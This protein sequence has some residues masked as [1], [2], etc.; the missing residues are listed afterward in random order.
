MMKPDRQLVCVLG[1]PGTGKGTQGK[2]LASYL[3]GVHVSVGDLIRESEAAGRRVPKDR[4]TK[5]AD[6][7]AT[8]ELIMAAAGDVAGTVVLDGFPRHAS[9]VEALLAMPWPCRT[10]ID[11]RVTFPV[12][13]ARMKGRGR[14]GEDPGRIAQRHTM[15]D[16]NRPGLEVALAAARIALVPV[17]GEGT[18]DE[19]QNLCR[20][21]IH[22]HCG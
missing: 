10:A 1:A 5:L 21:V 11:L 3:Q 18:V 9:Q 14:D 4:K 17:D 19:V 8:M 12:A 6:T 2:L 16:I 22:S 20:N 7:A 15:H 13:F